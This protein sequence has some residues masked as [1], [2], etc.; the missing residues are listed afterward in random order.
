[1]AEARF[2]WD[3]DKESANQK[4]HGVPFHRANTPLPILD[5][6]SQR[7]SRTV[8]RKTVSIVLVKS[9]AAS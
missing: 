2:E 9:M 7:I 4:K 3:P 6:S 5:V 1:M 8:S